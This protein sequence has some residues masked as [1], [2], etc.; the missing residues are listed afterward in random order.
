MIEYQATAEWWSR[1]SCA[2]DEQHWKEAVQE[3]AELLHEPNP[4]VKPFVSLATVIAPEYG[5]AVGSGVFTKCWEFEIQG[6]PC[7][8]M[9]AQ[10]CF[11]A[12]TYR[13]YK[14]K[15]TSFNDA[16][17]WLEEIAVPDELQIK[18]RPRPRGLIYEEG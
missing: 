9:A 17:K 18:R 3:V 6:I 12:E 4:Y 15:L 8:I 16:Q 7:R 14:H 5:L 2:V 1:P 13:Y 10:G 11:T